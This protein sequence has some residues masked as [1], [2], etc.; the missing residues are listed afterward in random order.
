M[1][2]PGILLLAFA[3]SWLALGSQ[4]AARGRDFIDE[5]LFSSAFRPGEV[6]LEI[7]A[8]SRLDTSYRLQGWY[9][10]ELEIALTRRLFVEGV[11]E[12][13]SRGQGLEWG[14]W[15]AGGRLHLGGEPRLPVDATLAM[16]FE[17]KTAVGKLPGTE[18]ELITRIVVTRILLHDVLVTANVGP[19]HRFT[20]RATRVAYGFGARWPERQ[21]LMVGL[22]W[23]REP[24]E[25]STRITPQL[26]LRLPNAW[27]LRLGGVFGV[28][29]RPYWFIARS[30]LEVEF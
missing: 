2:P 6:G 23:S 4:V 7:G 8:E 29:P 1:R 20:P 18:R 21:P 3:L 5:T 17:E 9:R 28:D 25:L 10:T 26:W 11:G 27:R 13:A 30:I 16:E 14:G 15:R 22:E 19:A 12:F 24:L